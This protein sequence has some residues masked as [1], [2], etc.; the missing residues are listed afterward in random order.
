MNP[1]DV[2]QAVLS[3]V[4]EQ[5]DG[6][7]PYSQDDPVWPHASLYERHGE[8]VRDFAYAIADRLLETLNA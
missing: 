5:C 3:A 4:L 7:W 8:S 6:T 2:R 1:E